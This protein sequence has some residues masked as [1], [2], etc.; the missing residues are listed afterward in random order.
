MD[1]LTSAEKIVRR[2]QQGRRGDDYALRRTQQTEELRGSQSS[3]LRGDLLYFN[4]LCLVAVVVAV[5][6]MLRTS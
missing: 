2:S 5:I 6:P 3:G 1:K 4:G